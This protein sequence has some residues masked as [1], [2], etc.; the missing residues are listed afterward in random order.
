MNFQLLKKIEFFWEIFFEF[1]KE[2]KLKKKKKKLFFNFF[3]LKKI[4]F[5][6]F[7]RKT[8]QIIKKKKIDF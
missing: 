7:F 1:W 6:L 3:Y 5:Y 2:M 4:D 8:I